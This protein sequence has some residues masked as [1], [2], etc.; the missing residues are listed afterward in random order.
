MSEGDTP[1][2]R[3]ASAI[4]LGRNRERLNTRIIEIFRN[5]QALQLLQLLC[6]FSLAFNIA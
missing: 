3:E 6:K 4:V 5:L 1:G 2:I